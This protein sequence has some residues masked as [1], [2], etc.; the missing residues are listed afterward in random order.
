VIA[1]GGGLVL[2]MLVGVLFGVIFRNMT[3]QSLSSLSA[4]FFTHIALTMLICAA[5]LGALLFAL[6]NGRGALSRGR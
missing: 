5:V 1:T 4:L 2:L 3:V 6:L